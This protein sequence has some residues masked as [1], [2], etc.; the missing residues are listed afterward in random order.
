LAQTRKNR[1][2]RRTHAHTCVLPKPESLFPVWRVGCLFSFFFLGKTFSY[3]SKISLQNAISPFLHWSIKGHSPPSN[4]IFP[5]LDH[6]VSF[7]VIQNVFLYFFKFRPPKL[8][9]AV[10]FSSPYSTSFRIMSLMMYIYLRSLYELGEPDM[11]IFAVLDCRY[12][13]I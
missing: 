13:R 4:S 7:K 6:A 2:N 11:P 5:S 3:G 10:W 12:T 1:Q 8:I 9:G